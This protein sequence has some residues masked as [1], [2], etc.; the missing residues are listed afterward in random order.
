MSNVNEKQ[1]APEMYNNLVWL[2]AQRQLVTGK[3]IYR[4]F[5]Q[6]NCGPRYTS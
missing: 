2:V 4:F 1:A 6:L 3:N 5:S